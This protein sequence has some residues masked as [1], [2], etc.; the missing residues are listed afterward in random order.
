MGEPL[1]AISITVKSKS[2]DPS[3]D[4]VT[5]DCRIS[6]GGQDLNSATD[7]KLAVI[8][9][10]T[11]GSKPVLGAKVVA[12]VER[13]QG[14]PIF[15]TLKDDGSSADKIRND[16]IYSRYFT[17]YRGTGRF[18]VRCQVE[19]DDSTNVNGGFTGGQKG[20]ASKSFPQKPD[21]SNPVC[22]GS[23]A[24]MPGASLSKT[25]NF[26]RKAAGGSFQVTVDHGSEDTTPPSKVTDLRLTEITSETAT[27]EFT[28]PGDNLDSEEPPASYIVKLTAGNSTDFEDF[29]VEVT[30]A[31]L[32][33]SSLDPVSGGSNKRLSI[34][35]TKFEDKTR[36][37]AGVRALDEGGLLSPTSNLASIFIEQ[38]PLRTH[39]PSE[40]HHVASD[41]CL[42]FKEQAENFNFI[43][44]LFSCRDNGGFLAELNSDL[45]IEAFTSLLM[46]ESSK[47]D[48]SQWWIGLADYAEEGKWRWLHSG[49]DA[50]SSIGQWPEVDNGLLWAPGSPD[51]N[52]D[53]NYDCAY[54]TV[55]GRSVFLVDAECDFSSHIAPVCQCAAP[56]CV[57][58]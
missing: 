23:D 39:C 40:F 32:V 5:T 15:L 24:L 7:V 38:R 10:V 51:K 44:S 43:D 1:E 54:A 45:R 9:E 12:E 50:T 13:P 22:C 27:L 57:F 18:S 3:T 58:P 55:V 14:A 42:L 53:N 46:D 28:S 30:D 36:Y 29:E 47:S 31:D 41:N 26:T 35:L 11:Q 56:H 52:P 33:D 25:G 48:I 20:W 2:R 21:P 4:P 19:G 16:G 8:A 6:T 17:R 34:K 37:L 49:E